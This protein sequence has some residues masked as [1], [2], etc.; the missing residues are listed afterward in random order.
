VVLDLDAK[1]SLFT[2]VIG[3]AR[4]VGRIGREA[5]LRALVETS[6]ATGIQACLAM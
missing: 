6:G 3:I 1:G 2:D 4:V 5:G